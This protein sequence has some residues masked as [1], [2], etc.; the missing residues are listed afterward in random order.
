[1]D[2]KT[3][4]QASFAGKTDADFLT[5]NADVVTIFSSLAN[6]PSV[7]RWGKTITQHSL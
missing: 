7:G 5:C 6:G 1:M 2:N 4:M 3:D